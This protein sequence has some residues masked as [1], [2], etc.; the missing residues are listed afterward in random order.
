MN[1]LC[2]DDNGIYVGNTIYATKDSAEKSAKFLNEANIV[3][4]IKIEWVK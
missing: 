2:N 4:T 3:S 1:I